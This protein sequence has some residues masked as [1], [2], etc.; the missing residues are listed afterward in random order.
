MSAVTGV[1]RF[2]LAYMYYEYGGKMYFQAMGGEGAEDFLAE[3]IT[4]EFMPRSNPN[5]SRVREGF[6]EA[7]RGL[8]DKGLIVLRGF[9]I[10]LTDEGKR[11]ASRVPQ[12]EYQEVKKRFRS[13]K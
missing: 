11:L 12:E 5:F 4:E 10:V 8:R 6:A 13:T 9:E 1:E 3:F 2:L 7:L